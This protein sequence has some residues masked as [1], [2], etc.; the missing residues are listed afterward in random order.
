MPSIVK[1][2]VVFCLLAVA[3]FYITA[4]LKAARYTEAI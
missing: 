3:G 4:R 1:V 2:E